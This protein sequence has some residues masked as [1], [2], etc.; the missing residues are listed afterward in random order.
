MQQKDNLVIDTRLGANNILAIIPYGGRNSK[1]TAVAP[2]TTFGRKL[3]EHLHCFIVINSK[4]RPSIVDMNDV[5]AIRKRKKIT[6]DFL[7]RIREFKDEIHENNLIPIILIIQQGSEQQQTDIVLGYGQGERGREDRPHR[8]TM[9]PSMLSKIRMSLEDNGFST[10]L[11]D[12]DS[13]LCGR[14]S[15]C[16]N[17]LFRQ[18]NYISGFYDPTVR[19]LVVTIAPEKLTDE[20]C[21]ADTARLFSRALAEYGDSMSL[22]RRVAVSAIETSKPQDLRYIFRVHGDN[23]ENDMI[24]ESYI[25][26]LARSIS[27]NGLLH[28][29]VL[30]QKK[31][32]RYK[33]LCGFRR[34]QAIRRLG[35][36]W[37][38]AK[39]FNEDDFTT[40]DF[41]NISLAENT[42][43]RNLNPIE[44]G[45]FLESA[46]KELGLNNARLAERF[47]DSLA[48]GKPGAHVSQSTIH[49]YRKLYQ[50]KERGESPEMISD[51]IN[52]KLRF[53][54]AAE[55]LA[56]IK[57]PVDRDSLYLDIVKPL[58]PTRPQLIRIIKILRSIHPSL[59]QA[60]SDPHVQKIL[61]QAIHSPHRANSFIN[62]L[63]KAGEQ[64]PEK[65]KQTFTS[66]VEA[67]R[68]EVFGAKANKQDFN[69]TRSL[70][71]R[72]KSLTLHIRFQ[73]DSM[74]QVAANL[75]QLLADKYRLKELHTLLKESSD[76]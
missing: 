18:K 52:D 7:V 46:G 41:F 47:G 31:D 58:A 6:D 69:I 21:A 59:N 4:Y 56:P 32:G 61:E 12:T 3:V 60:V 45:N 23:P 28:P 44:I 35:R 71:G 11:A 8:P 1:N 9:A 53:S 66:T 34:F 20:N 2:M 42:K 62:G 19:S 75:K 73:E 15:Y 10:A 16:L 55:V 68:K 33:I 51:V 17:Q 67:L 27:A 37:V 64:Q 25:D 57:D 30:L 40:E 72:K 24:R 50:L 36:Q 54:I 76:S 43:R 22:V 74:E 70:K 29:L 48:I 26:E 49:K 13:L 39:T 38:E 14:E 5:R 65:S 63:R